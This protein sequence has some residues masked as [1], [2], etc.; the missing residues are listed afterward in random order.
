MVGQV[1]KARGK[2]KAGGTTARRGKG[3]GEVEKIGREEGS[4]I[5]VGKSLLDIKGI[6]SLVRTCLFCESV[7]CLSLTQSKDRRCRSFSFLQAVAKL[8][9]YRGLERVDWIPRNF[10][11]AHFDDIWYLMSWWLWRIRN[12]L[13]K[14]TIGKL[15]FLKTALKACLSS[16]F[17]SVK[18]SHNVFRQ[19]SLLHSINHVLASFAALQIE[20]DLPSFNFQRNPSRELKPISRNSI[21]FHAA[22]NP[23]SRPH[24][25]EF[26]SAYETWFSFA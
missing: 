1:E 13:W 9:Q 23:E 7:F 15:N 24:P 22:Q 5:R 4:W 26:R 16:S 11:R 18:L 6:S 20:Y 17:A 2:R 8:F 19:S 25:V 14:P 3:L 21:W 10:F 12:R